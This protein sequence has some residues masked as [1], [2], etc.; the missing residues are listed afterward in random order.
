MQ[1]WTGRPRPYRD[2][3]NGLGQ[4]VVKTEPK[5]QITTGIVRYLYD[6]AGHLLGEYDG[7]GNPM[8]ETIYLANIPVVV[9]QAQ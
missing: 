8:Q 4:R 1:C 3:Y 5:T 2:L 6:E 9:L 7:M